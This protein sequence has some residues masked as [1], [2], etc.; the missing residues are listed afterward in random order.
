MTGTETGLATVEFVLPCVLLACAVIALGLAAW[1]SLERGRLYAVVFA[2]L[3][4]YGAFT[5]FE[6]PGL[7][8]Q[9]S[10]GSATTAA[11]VFVVGTAF[12]LASVVLTERRFPRPGPTRMAD[13][14]DR[15]DAAGTQHLAWARL[16]IPA[17]LALLI[18]SREN[19]EL[20][21]SEARADA[22]VVEVGATFLFLLGVPGAVTGLLTGKRLQG[23]L[24]LGAA[25]VVFVISGS[26]A[27]LLGGLAYF[28]WIVLARTKERP[29]RIRVMAAMAGLAF[30]AHV[31][32][33]F[34]RGF[35][36]VALLAALSSGD[37]ASLFG[38]SAAASDIS[39]GEA[40]IAR[41]F[42]F[43]V[44]HAGDEAFGFMTSVQRLLLLFLPGKA[45]GIQ[46]PLDVTYQL[47]AEGYAHGLFDGAQGFIILQ[48]AFLT[49]SLGSLHPTLFGE[50]FLAGRWPALVATSILFGMLSVFIDR[51]LRSMSAVSALLLLGPMLVGLLMVGRGNSVI[52]FGYFFYLGAFV[53]P[54][55]A[56]LARL[57]AVR[58]P[59]Q[60]SSD[61]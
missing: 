24:L 40:A 41:Y 19:L 29:R 16:A 2:A 33:R 38:E 18:L 23:A 44:Q 30:L 15:L 58:P 61:P 5:L 17:S 59:A 35:G 20:T 13:W 37:L 39:G 8:G 4:M 51:A 36:P 14:A 9:F 45:L 43:S 25:L 31:V 6:L 26:R 57:R 22:G 32:L 27:A 56:I 42:V 12:F 55:N 1:A 49:G 3:A 28:A 50:L 34:L 46:K 10:D 21:W 60:A 52:G 54:V 48:D 11:L 7:A 53:V 47:W